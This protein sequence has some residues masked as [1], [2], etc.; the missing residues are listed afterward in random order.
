MKKLF[1]PLLAI[2]PLL[3][4]GHHSN[5][6]YD[7]NVVQELQG[8]ILEVSW[9]NPHVELVLKTVA[10][11]G[12]EAIWDLEAQ[13]VNSLRRRGLDGSLISVGDIVR[14][15]GNASTI[16][17]NN[18]SVSNLLLPSGTEISIRGRTQPRCSFVRAEY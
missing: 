18:L 16:R 3:A 4:Q 15:A 7:F 13:D 1:V 2:T 9:R 17:P 12:T 14:V 11:D 10:G 6:E 5:A 8:E